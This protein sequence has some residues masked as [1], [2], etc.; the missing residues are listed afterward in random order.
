MN[1]LK[2]RRERARGGKEWNGNLGAIKMFLSHVLCFGASPARWGLQG[3]EDERWKLVVVPLLPGNEGVSRTEHL[4]SLLFDFPPHTHT[5]APLVLKMKIFS[6]HIDIFRR[7]SPWRRL[8]VFSRLFFR[9]GK[10]TKA[11]KFP[12]EMK[13]M[14]YGQ[15]SNKF[16]PDTRLRKLFSVGPNKKSSVIRSWNSFNL[17]DKTT[18]AKRRHRQVQSPE[19]VKLQGDVMESLLAPAFVL[20]HIISSKVK[21]ISQHKERKSRKTK[22]FPRTMIDDE[23]SRKKEGSMCRC[24]ITFGEGDFCESRGFLAPLMRRKGRQKEIFSL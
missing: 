5:A 17:Q 22:N 3:E 9:Q 16:S 2:G 10:G 19:V 6:L 15:R 23:K 14:I 7:S 12:C 1:F 4:F 11:K 18:E 20:R 21:A 24:E 13:L 8:S